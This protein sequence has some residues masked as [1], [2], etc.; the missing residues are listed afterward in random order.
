VDN[1][2]AQR[3]ETIYLEKKRHLIG[4][5]E[6]RRVNNIHFVGIGGVG[7]CGLAQVL[8]NQGYNVSG[9]DQKISSNTRHL[10]DLGIK[11]H[12]GHN[13]KNLKNVD[14]VVVSTA[15]HSDNPELAMARQLRVPVISRAE[16]LA[17]IMRYRHGIAVAGTHGKT[18]TTSMIASILGHAQLDP[19]FIIGGRLNSVGSNAGLGDSRILVAEADESD[20]S[21]IHLQPMVTVVTNI[22]ADHMST[23]NGD[24][25][26]LH[27]TFIS[28]LHNL[29]FY[30]LAVVCIDDPAI[31]TLLPRIKR[32]IITYGQSA[33]ADIQAVNILQEATRT[34]FDILDH[35]N[36][37]I[38]SLTMNVPGVHNVLNAIAAF[39][40]AKEEGVAPK[41]IIEGLA[42]FTGVDRRFQVY[43]NFSTSSGN[44]FFVDDYGHHPTEVA[45][46]INAIRK[47]WPSRRLVM[48]FQPHRYSRTY[49]M[50]EDFVEVLSQVD[51]L[52]LLDVYAAGEKPIASA[53]SKSL[54]GSIRQRGKVDPIFISRDMTVDSVLVDI[55]QDDDFLLTQ[56]AGDIG[57][58]ARELSMKNLGFSP[59]G[60]QEYVENC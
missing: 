51:V 32:H 10:T 28:F 31:R 15:I 33:D 22:E 39:S 2:K 53:D 58:I 14:V 17:E 26:R 41:T 4:I 54:C 56:G 18:T 49:D 46:T 57:Q 60:E 55:L 42:N 7:M 21:F 16:M 44:V 27:D 19:T 8:K 6:M 59:M 3:S 37:A 25:D 29:P 11:V 5:P 47:G 43:G 38:H 24:I 12:I 40:V 52:L 48:V 36:D 13:E 20:A 23:Y 34:S 1:S 9:S 50:Y 45:A 30:G 35:K